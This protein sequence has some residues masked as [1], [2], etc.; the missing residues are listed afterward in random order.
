LGR[1]LDALIPEEKTETPPPGSQIIQVPL[2]QIAPNPEQPRRTFDPEAIDDLADSIREYGVLEPV[3]VTR[4]GDRYV[5][6]AGERRVIAS[7]HAG[8]ETIPAIEREGDAEEMLAIAVIENVQRED[9]NAIEEAHAYRRLQDEFGLTQE[10]ISG[11]VGKSRVTVANTLRLLQL[12]R[13]IQDDVSRG[14]LSAGH[15]RAILS[16]DDPTERERLW[17]TIKDQQ[18]NVRAA[19]D[20]ARKITGPSGRKKKQ[21]RATSGRQD[22]HLLHLEDRLRQRLGTQVHIVTQPRGG[23]IEIGYFGSEDL[24]RLLEL[25]GVGEDL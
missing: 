25:M 5:L 15:A 16:V 24:E 2:E 14:T 20:S 7:R 17:K 12:P 13:E 6:V 4:N 23:R 11:R 10:E 22:P 18:L 21:G 9:L 3:L 1:G 19:E 8:M